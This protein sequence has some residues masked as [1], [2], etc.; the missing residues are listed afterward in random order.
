MSKR[1][2]LFIENTLITSYKGNTLLEDVYIEH[3]S[4]PEI[5][6]DEIDTTVDFLGNKISFPLIINAMTGGTEKGC[7]INEM[8]YM[9]SKE[10]NIPM[11]VGSQIELLDSDD[12]YLE[13]LFLGE[14]LDGESSDSVLIS[15]LSANSSLKDI[16]YVMNVIK[17]KAIAVHLNSAQEVAAKDGNKD[18]RNIVENI[19]KIAE[20][21]PDNLIVKEIGFGMSEKVV[22]TLVDSGVKIIDISGFGGTNFLEI[23]NLRCYEYDFSDLYGWGIPTAK[24]I[25]NARNVDKDIIII[26][27]GGIKSALDIVK[28]LVLG[29][30]YVGI[31][32]EL[33]RYLLHGGYDQA[34]QYL[35]D[36][37]YKVKMLMFL[38]G[39]KSIEDLKKVEYKIK[40]ELKDLLDA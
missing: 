30:D 24:A 2:D 29:A 34:K 25:I 37:M 8:L 39:V 32:G 35:L 26:A 6:F 19:K 5:S 7:E 12:S 27:S 16:E 4:L 11:E 3:N 15:N 10:L 21:Y 36:V 38:L 22:K 9:I 28:A 31:A 18:F 14:T 20:K 1:R 33:L 40:G 13:Q 17:A 23:E